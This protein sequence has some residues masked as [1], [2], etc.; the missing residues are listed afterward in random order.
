MNIKA[1]CL[2]INSKL[3]DKGINILSIKEK[4]SHKLTLQRLMFVSDVCIFT[5]SQLAIKTQF[6]SICKSRRFKH[7]HHDRLLDH[8]HLSLV[9]ELFKSTNNQSQQSTHSF[10]MGSPDFSDCIKNC[11]KTL[12]KQRCHHC[13]II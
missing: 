4:L 9:L 1:V 6:L 8:H 3:K 7:F 12:I 13:L 2:W 11:I 10:I 5:K